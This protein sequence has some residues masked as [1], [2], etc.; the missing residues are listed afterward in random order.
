MKIL[1]P[2]LRESK[3]Y[4]AFSLTAEKDISRRDLINELNFAAATLVGDVG[5]SE[6]SMHL[7]SFDDC[8]GIMQCAANKVWESRGV[9]ASISSIKGVRVRLTVLGV[10]G[11]VRASTQNYLL[12]NDIKTSE[13]E[14]ERTAESDECEFFIANNA[15]SGKV[16]RRNNNE[17]DILPDSPHYEDKL[18]NS[19]TRYFGITVFD[20][21]D[22]EIE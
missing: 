15:I 14:R 19:G 18:E 10:S 2:T 16:V 21:T 22:K 8:N 20:I 4:L 1:P 13:P 7:L 12:I 11:T 6:L 9:M 3:R 17:I 5:C